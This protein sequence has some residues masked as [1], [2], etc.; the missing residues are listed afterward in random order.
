MERE[1]GLMVLD[2]DLTNTGPL[3]RREEP[4]WE[5]LDDQGETEMIW[6]LVQELTLTSRGTEEEL[7]LAR[8]VEVRWASQMGLGLEI[9][10]LRVI[11]NKTVMVN[12]SESDLRIDLVITCPDQVLTHH[13]KLRELGSQWEVEE[14]IEAGMMDL[15]QEITIPPLILQSLEHQEQKW[16]LEEDLDSKQQMGLHQETT[17]S[18]RRGEAVSPWVPD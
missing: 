5:V 12:P 17:T 7:P 13:Q 11:F 10:T 15:D 4:R 8:T 6:V 3:W 2:L 16:E 1:T 18:T 14:R 9:M